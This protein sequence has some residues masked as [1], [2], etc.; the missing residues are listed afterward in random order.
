MGRMVQLVSASAESLLRSAYLIVTS[1]LKNLPQ[2]QVSRRKLRRGAQ[3]H[4][5]APPEKVLES[6]LLPW[7]PSGSTKGREGLAGGVPFLMG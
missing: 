7:V 5:P 3:S 4:L 6:R 1:C 2:T